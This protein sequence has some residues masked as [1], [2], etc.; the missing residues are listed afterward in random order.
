MGQTT[1]LIVLDDSFSG[2]RSPSNLVTWL[3]VLKNTKKGT[4]Q[5][6]GESSCGD[7]GRVDS[8]LG[9]FLDS[10]DPIDLGDTRDG[11]WVRFEGLTPSEGFFIGEEI[12]FRGE[13]FVPSDRFSGMG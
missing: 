3:I 10:C 11:D 8:K 2:Q 7:F 13:S 4:P 5:G 6:D 1:S 9:F 12:L